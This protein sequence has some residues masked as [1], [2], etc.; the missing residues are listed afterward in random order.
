ME[1]QIKKKSFNEKLPKYIK[2]TEDCEHITILQKSCK[3]KQKKGG[4]KNKDFDEAA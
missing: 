3:K 4:F 2:Y 1:R